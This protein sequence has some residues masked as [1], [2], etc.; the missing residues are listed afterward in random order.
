M[1]SNFENLVKSQI[2]SIL[3]VFINSI[4]S[5]LE[6][7]NSFTQEEREM[8]YKDFLN[9]LEFVSSYKDEIDPQIK[10]KIN[11]IKHLLNASN[12]V[13]EGEEHPLNTPPLS[14]MQG[15]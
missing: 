2:N 10:D 11:H 4:E 3:E 1:D 8:L 15:N 6:D 13:Y 5:V 12:E 7:K 9:V 14:N